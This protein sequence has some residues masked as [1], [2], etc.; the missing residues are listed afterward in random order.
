MKNR[1][2]LI[3]LIMPAYNVADYIESAVN[4]AIGQTYANWELVI[5]DDASSD[6][7]MTPLL[8]KIAQS[9]PRIRVHCR[10]CNSGACYQPRCDAM[11]IAL[12][13]LMCEYDA[14]DLLAPDYLR[15]L[16]DV[17][18]STGADMVLGRMSLLQDGRITPILPT[19]EIDTRRVYRGRDLVIHTLDGWK[20]CFNGGLIKREIY[21]KSYREVN[22]P[23]AP[24]A[25]EIASRLM[26]CNS[27]T[28]AFSDAVYFYRTN[29]TSVT[30]DSPLRNFESL[31]CDSEVS[32]FVTSRFAPDSA[33]AD[34]AYSQKFNGVVMSLVH[35]ASLPKTTPGRA[36]ISSRVRK[37]YRE[38]HKTRR[39]NVSPKI[40]A[41]MLTGYPVASRLIPMYHRLKQR[42]R[43]L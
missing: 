24:R 28:V 20:I 10:K 15:S 43:R 16:L 23:S 14:D 42:L 35:L 30:R 6:S 7:A 33:E 8:D 21:K 13:E 32:D 2:P 26:L 19:D 5:V 36:E 34:M 9:D 3:S 4:A 12:G 11:D 40:L 41:L 39:G 17:M 31:I 1:E 25:D 18:L 22:N 27:E 38:L 29:P 37:A